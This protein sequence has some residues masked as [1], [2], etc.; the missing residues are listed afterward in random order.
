[1]LPH[2]ESYS[3]HP[4]KE[5]ILQGEGQQLDFKFNISS[6]KKIAKTFVAFANTDGG[7][8]LVGVKD[9]GKIA[10]VR[11]DEE[12]YMLDAAATM[13]CR[14]NVDYR[15]KEWEVDD[16]LVLEVNIPPSK[17][18][19]H[20]AEDENGKWLAYIRWKDNNLLANRVLVEVMKRKKA[21][22]HTL[23]RYNKEQRLLLEHLHEHGQITQKEF[24]KLAKLG[25]WKAERILINF[26]A[27]EVIDI[28]IEPGEVTYTLNEEGERRLNESV[29]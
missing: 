20:L 9:N 14:P 16:R 2:Q 10:G 4:I 5:L 29:L 26:A 13:Y 6:S 22:K 24:Q 8:L 3:L 15:V 23:I 12:L 21:G 28:H 19:P 11:T 7:R 18:R 1:M 27:V 25:K 17:E